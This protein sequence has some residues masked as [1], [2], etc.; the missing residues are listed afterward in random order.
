MHIIKNQCPRGTGTVD[1]QTC[2]RCVSNCPDNT[3]VNDQ[4]CTG[5]RFA[6]VGIVDYNYND[7]SSCLGSCRAENYQ[8]RVGGCT[9]QDR[10]AWPECQQCSGIC[11]V[12]EYVLQMC[13]AISGTGESSPPVCAPCTEQCPFGTYFVST[14][15]GQSYGKQDIQ[16]LPCQRCLPGQYIS[17]GCPGGNRIRNDTRQ[18]SNCTSK[19]SA[20]YYLD[21]TCTGIEIENTVRCLPCRAYCNVPGQYMHAPCNGTTRNPDSN[22]CRRC[23]PCSAGEFMSAGACINGTAVSPTHRTC[24]ACRTCMQ[25]QYI[26]NVCSGLGTQDTQTCRSCNPCPRGSYISNPCDGGYATDPNA[27]TCTPCKTCPAGF[28]RVGCSGT[29]ERDDVQCVPCKKCAAGQWIQNRCNGST[30]GDEQQVCVACEAC[31]LGNYYASGCTGVEGSPQKTCAPC[32]KLCDPGKFVAKGCRGDAFS[33]QDTPSVCAECSKSCP[34]DY[35]M[36]K[37]QYVQK[38]CPGNTFVTGVAICRECKCLIPGEYF[39]QR[40]S[41]TNGLQDFICSKGSMGEDLIAARTT[42]TATTTAA[43]LQGKTSTALVMPTTTPAPPS[44]QQPSIFQDTKTLAGIVGGAAAFV[45]VAGFCMYRVCS[46][47]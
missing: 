45:L 30:F 11:A 4:V 36:L 16:C 12:G 14:C 44:S 2:E 24:R 35:Y 22:D 40:C 3:F 43:S 27:R 32:K 7:C 17:K 41:G 6:D 33:F 47:H 29:S 5:Y 46:V 19:C 25:G 26:S 38:Q 1:T 42:F 23:T 20:G 21:G 10:T 15:T 9:G 28:Y 34:F 39:T 18:C 8:I 31:G 13:Q 37:D